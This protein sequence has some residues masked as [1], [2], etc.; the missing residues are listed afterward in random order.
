MKEVPKKDEPAVSGGVV[1]GSL[2]GG[3]LV[4]PGMPLPYPQMPT[5]PCFP[6]PTRQVEK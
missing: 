6:D 3:P 4:I 2:P 1:P 5:I